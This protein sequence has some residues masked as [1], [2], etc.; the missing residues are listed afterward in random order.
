MDT[1]NLI[2]KWNTALF[3]WTI[4]YQFKELTGEINK[5]MGVKMFS[6]LCSS[7]MADIN[8]PPRSWH[9][10]YLADITFK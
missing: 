1:P 5:E 10:D 2:L 3:T 8:W 4:L 9:G 7:R 6:W